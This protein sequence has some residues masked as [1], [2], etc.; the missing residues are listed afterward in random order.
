MR[1]RDFI[2]L[3]G[4]AAAASPP[5]ARAQQP[6]MPVI[7]YLDP[8]S[9]LDRE[10]RGITPA[11]RHGL[12][13]AGYIE[14]RNVGIEYRWADNQYDRLPALASD[15]V[16]RRVA[17]IASTGSTA[18]ALAAKGATTTIPI[19]F[20]MGADP[21]S[22]GLVASLNRPGGNITGVSFLATQA[23]AKML[24]VLHEII[25]SA[26]VV[27]ALI[28]PTNPNSEI[29]KGDLQGAAR[30]LGLELYF[31]NASN[32]RDIDAAFET[33]VQR[34]TGALYVEG[35][36]FFG[37]RRRQL[38]AL[39]LRHTIPAIFQSRDFPEIGGLMSYGTDVR[40]AARIA[41]GYVARILKGDRPADLPVQQSTKVE[42][43]INLATA[44]AL[45]LTVPLPLLASA[46]E[47]IE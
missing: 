34:R 2:T 10:S 5:V 23:A 44:K 9:S 35:D 12:V 47:V 1:R 36:P 3:L 41:A 25:P 26:A 7:G 43:V 15:L 39:T 16:R 13:E 33:L 32:E 28:N 11:F 45:G 17:L 6:A 27:A 24:Q 38:A 42:L 29:E 20:T 21:V 19:V 22:V 46:D 14:G 31:L 37:S 4:G 18:A 40:E 30:V 8:G